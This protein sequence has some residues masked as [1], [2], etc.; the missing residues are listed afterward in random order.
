M[1]IAPPP[2]IDI[3]APLTDLLINQ[4][5]ISKGNFLF[6]CVVYKAWFTLCRICNDRLFSLPDGCI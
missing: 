4:A 6:L 5:D 2:I 1:N 3:L